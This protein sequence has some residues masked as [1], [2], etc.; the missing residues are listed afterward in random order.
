MQLENSLQVIGLDL[1]DHF[2]DKTAKGREDGKLQGESQQGESGKFRESG[3]S[4]KNSGSDDSDRNY[5]DI[6]A[7]RK[8]ILQ[9]GTKVPAPSLVTRQTLGQAS[10]D[11][12]QSNAPTAN[13]PGR[14]HPVPSPAGSALPPGLYERVEEMLPSPF[15]DYDMVS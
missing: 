11:S 6:D 14:H 3:R 12:G 7:L 9:P 15:A 10:S 4:R 1:K 13:V 5:A 8:Q 2:V